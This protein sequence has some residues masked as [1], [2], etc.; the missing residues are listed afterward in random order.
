M[1]YLGRVRRGTVKAFGGKKGLD[2]T[3]ILK[4]IIF[5]AEVL[6]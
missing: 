3:K 4:K 2:L 1:W 6:Q 5:H